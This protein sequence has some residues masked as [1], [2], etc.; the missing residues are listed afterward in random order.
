MRK[1]R[2]LTK[3]VANHYATDG[4]RI[5]EFSFPGTDKLLGGLIS[6]SYSNDGPIV[7][8]YRVDKEV[9]VFVNKEK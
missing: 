5:I 9:Q 2:V 4:Q 1:P 3:C 7:S 6:F 8:L